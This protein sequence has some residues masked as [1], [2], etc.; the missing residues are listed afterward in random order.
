MIRLPL[1][2]DRQIPGL[3]EAARIATVYAAAVPRAVAVI[4]EK[5]GAVAE[6]TDLGLAIAIPVARRRE[7]AGLTEGGT[8]IGNTPILLAVAIQK[9]FLVP[10]RRT[11]SRLSAPPPSAGCAS[12]V[13]RTRLGGLAAGQPTTAYHLSVLS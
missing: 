8:A 2:R 12:A 6:H 10:E 4:V 13:V 7:I 5:P 3:A 11:P 9:P 1:A